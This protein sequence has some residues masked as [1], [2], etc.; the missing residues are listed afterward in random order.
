MINHTDLIKKLEAADAGSVDLDRDVLLVA[1]PNV[2]SRHS[3]HAD[4]LV[5]SDWEP[6]MS[7]WPDPTQSVD[8]A[9]ALVAEKLPELTDWK[10]KPDY[11]WISWSLYSEASAKAKTPTI[12]LC[13][14]LLKALEPE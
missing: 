12:A 7:V 4:K 9:L 5:L 1:C 6:P 10:L 13:I 3:E 8:A 2:W 11:A 14:A